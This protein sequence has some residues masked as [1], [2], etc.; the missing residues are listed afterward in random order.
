VGAAETRDAGL[1]SLDVSGSGRLNGGRTSVD[2]SVTAGASN[3][4]RVTGSAPLSADGALDLTISGRLEAGL[5]NVALSTGGRQVKGALVVAMQ[6]RGT[7]MK[8]D[9]RGIVSLSNG[10][11]SDDATGFKLT[12]LSA[13]ATATGDTIRIDRFS[14][15]TP[16]G[17]TM[18]ASGEV[19]LDPAAGFPGAI[20][21]MGTR[22]Q[23]VATDIVTATANV[24]LDLTGRLSQSPTVSGR[25]AIVSMDVTIPQRFSGLASPIPGTKHLHPT[26]TARAR[27][28]ELAKA[29]A[30]A[31][32]SPFNATLAF[33][34]SAPNR[35]FIRGRGVNA[36]FGGDVRFAGTLRAPQVS[37]GFDLLRGTLAL[38]GRPLNFTRGKVTF[39]GDVIPELDLVAETTAADITA[40]IEVSGPAN[41]P[42]FAITSS[43]SLPEDEILARLLFQEPSGNLSAF[44]AIELANAAATLSGT[45]TLDP[46]RRSLGLSSLG[47][48]TGGGGLLGLGRVINDRISVDVTTGVTPQQNGVNVNLDVTRH[49]RLQ[50]GVDASGGT[51]VGVGA[52]WECK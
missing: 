28:A 39:H 37:G 25:I 21:I 14:G 23:L 29:R 24:N 31:G 17:G 19:K 33:D 47:L 52:D 7:I 51:D 4:L 15:A 12:G 16:N 18:T 45:D 41:H 5:A 50:A 46:F 36:E 43:P 34:V 38:V 13:T 42:T 1:P 3:A 49:I 32:R 8:P 20:R 48:G 22:A 2:L 44:Q 40:R 6:A 26:P 27:L 9:V 30:G 10:A 35:V 11:F